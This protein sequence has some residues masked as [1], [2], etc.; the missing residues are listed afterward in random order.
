MGTREGQVREVS[1]LVGKKRRRI[2][3]KTLD[4][5]LPFP[6]N[7][8]EKDYNELIITA[9][10][11][12]KLIANTFNDSKVYRKGINI[13]NAIIIGDLD[14]SNAEVSPSVSM[15]N[16][17]FLGKLNLRNSWFRRELNLEG[18]HFLEAADFNELKVDHD[19]VFKKTLFRGKVD[20][21]GATIAE[22]AAVG[23]RFEST[24]KEAAFYC[25]KVGYHARFENA[26]FRGPVNFGSAD[27]QYFEANG[28]RFESTEKEVYFNSLKVGGSAHFKNAVFRGPVDFGY[29]N[30]GSNFDAN[31]ARFESTEKEANFNSLKVDKSAFFDKAVFRGPVNFGWANIAGS[32]QALGARFESKEKEVHFDSLKVG[33]GAFFDKAVFCGPV[34]FSFANIA[35]NFQ[36]LGAR[37]ESIESA[38]SF[39]NLKVGH[40]VLFR[41]ALF[42]GPVNFG[43]ANIDFLHLEGIQFQKAQEIWLEG[44]TYKNIYTDYTKDGPSSDYKKV[45]EILSQMKAYGP[46]PYKQLESSY[47]GQGNKKAADAV[48]LEGQRQEWKAAGQ[49]RYLPANILKL[50][51]A[52]LSR[53]LNL[54]ICFAIAFI[55]IGT[56]VFS[57][58]TMFKDEGQLSVCSAF[59]YSLALFLP[60]VTLGVDKLH[61]IEKD[62]RLNLVNLYPRRFATFLGWVGS[63]FA[64]SL[65]GWVRSPQALRVEFYYYIHQL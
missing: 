22:F 63:G 65:P 36:A 55:I 23:A 45:L 21:I 54:V 14:L 51:A 3:A 17:F 27:I 62:A 15:S 34:S 2:G 52:W 11:L 53:A 12:E 28:A 10:F 49:G 1:R 41:N 26:V 19:A 4:V 5:S 30:T 60:F 6:K 43:W 25:L 7:L 38:A 48:F 20:F 39:E 61:Q 8:L 13:K 40:A 29:A 37:F 9:S 18:S 50:V 35:T 16:C 47:M 59:C 31:G 44:L 56:F 32:F 42:W 64:K 46:Q 58:P 57:R 24:E 33:Q